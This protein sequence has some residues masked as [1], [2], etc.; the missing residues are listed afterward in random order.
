MRPVF[1]LLGLC[2]FALGAV[3]AV[4]PG[5]PTTVFMILALWAF[6]RSS[7][8]FHHWLYHHPLFGPP[9]QEWQQYRV[10]PLRAKLLAVSMM[11]LSLGYVL[12][13]THLA[14]WIKL[15]TALGIVTG[16]WY[17][18]SKPSQRPAGTD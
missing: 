4:V 15:L 14:L 11:L 13:F 10:I 18:L 2:F 1:F 17:V 9:L 3:G 12:W 8:R 16:A 5:L 7:E 6:A